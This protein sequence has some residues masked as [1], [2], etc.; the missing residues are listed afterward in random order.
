MKRRVFLPLAGAGLLAASLPLRAQTTPPAR[1]VKV[2]VAWPAGGFMDVTT[3]A[4]TDRLANLWSQQVVVENKPGAYGLIGTEQVMYSPPDGATWLIGTMGTPMSASLY[5]RK[6]IAADEFAG[7]AMVG[8]SALIAVV[9]ASLPVQSMKEFVALARSQPGKLNYLNPSAGSATHLNTELLKLNEKINVTSVPYNG[10]PPG[11]VDLIA[12]QLHFGMLAPQVVGPHIR[13]GKLRAL[14]VAF[15][16]RL[17]DY[18]EVPTMAEAGYPDVTVVAS[19]SVLVPKRT[20]KDVIAKLNADIVQALGDPETRRRI[21]TAGAVAAGP[22]TPEQ[23][24]AFLRAE[25]QRWDRFFRD[26]RIDI[27]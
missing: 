27:E 15:P 22:S 26:V 24:D 19:Y 25:T 17:K 16:T 7:V 11:V 9:P 5:K 18:P 6:W 1:P 12:G 20:P 13:S 3:R 2:V 14:A 8:S 23:V 10:Q 4:M 21:E